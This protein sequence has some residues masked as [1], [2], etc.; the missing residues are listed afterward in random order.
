MLFVLDIITHSSHIT[1]ITIIYNPINRSYLKDII[2]YC[3][4]IIKYT[5][6]NAMLYSC[7]KCI[8]QLITMASI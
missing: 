2:L 7:H 6:K 5:N 4:K 8:S 3:P 1:T